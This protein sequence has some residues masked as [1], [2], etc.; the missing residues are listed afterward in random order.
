M[1]GELGYQKGPDGLYRDRVGELL[2]LEVRSTTNVDPRIAAAI[3]DQWQRLGMPSEQVI[4]PPQRMPDREYRATFPGFV[5]TGSGVNNQLGRLRASHSRETPLPENSFN[6]NN[7][8]R[9][10]NSAFDALVD[11]VVNTIP[12]Q[13]RTA[14]AGEAHRIMMD[15]VGVMTLWYG[16]VP[17]II[18]RNSIQN[19]LPPNP[20]GY[21]WRVNEWDLAR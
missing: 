14:L 19:V 16:I 17:G 11:R 7:T 2:K 3:V 13:E 1:L 10:R 18:L 6:G 9:W 8:S 21:L 20:N 4:I 12:L 15:D 5:Y